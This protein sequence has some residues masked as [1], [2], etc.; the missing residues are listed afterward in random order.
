MMR[1]TFVENGKGTEKDFNTAWKSF[2][3]EKKKVRLLSYWIRRVISGAV[4]HTESHRG[5][6]ELFHY[7][8]HIA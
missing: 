4:A 7:S 3:E 8:P 6:R 1:R 5:F 2:S